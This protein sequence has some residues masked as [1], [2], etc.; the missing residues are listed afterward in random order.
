MNSCGNYMNSQLTLTSSEKLRCCICASAAATE[1]PFIRIDSFQLMKCKSCGLVFLDQAQVSPA[2]FLDAAQLKNGASALEY[3]GYPDIF[4]KHKSVFETFFRKR[5]AI[6]LAKAPL[7]GDW[8][9]VGSGYG[10]WQSFLKEIGIGARGIEID[11]KAHKFCIEQGLDVEH[12]S[13]GNL[14]T[15]KKY[16]V[17]TMCDVLEHIKD[18]VTVLKKCH[19]LLIPGG[20]IY[21]QVPCVLG[22]RYP[23]KDSLGLPYHLW[24]FNPKTLKALTEK[25]DFKVEDYWTGIQGVIKHYEKGK[26]A[27]WKKYL[28]KIATLSKRGNRLQLLARKK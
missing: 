26:P 27:W 3:W 28:W 21:I 16:S 14:Q 10:L 6:I 11:E 15:H 1:A 25:C 17:I 12:V 5:L 23:Y 9:D 4:K 18:P 7:A 13:I 22:A 20:L 8:F 2:K 19:E 24:Q